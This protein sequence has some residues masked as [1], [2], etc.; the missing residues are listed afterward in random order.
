M[1]ADSYGFTDS[2]DAEIIAGGLNM[3]SPDSVAIGRHGNFLLWGFYASPSDLTPEARKCFVNAICYIKQFDGQKP[4][5]HKPK[6]PWR[7]RRW[8]VSYAYFYQSMC[9]RERFL[10]SQPEAT[11]KDPE[12]IDELHRTMVGV[13]RGQF[14]KE[15][16]RQFGNDPKRYIEYYRDNLEFLYP[17]ETTS[18]PFTVDEDVKGLGLSNRSIALPREVH[19]NAQAGR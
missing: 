15:L 10:N 19:L 14:P 12:K 5:V 17:N 6:G 3:K 8:A 1:V 9:D 16:Q 13:Y 2:P 7:S 11:R 18:L 4:I